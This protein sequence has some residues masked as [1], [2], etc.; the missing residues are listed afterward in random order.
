MQCILETCKA[1]EF[2]IIL[3]SEMRSLGKI[4][5]EVEDFCLCLPRVEGLCHFWTIDNKKNILQLS[6]IAQENG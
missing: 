3:F 1:Y 4:I 6:A 5:S 2:A